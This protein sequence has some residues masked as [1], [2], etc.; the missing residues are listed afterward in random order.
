MTRLDASEL[1]D[2]LASLP[3][4]QIAGLLAASADWKARAAAALAS[5]IVT[6]LN[7]EPPI[8]KDQLTLRL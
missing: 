6:R 3:A 5:D 1:A 4:S 7:G 2:V 8:D